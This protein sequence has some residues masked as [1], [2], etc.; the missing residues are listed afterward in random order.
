MQ[1][2][3]VLAVLAVVAA[4]GGTL[5]AMAAVARAT[6]WHFRSVPLHG[7]SAESWA[8]RASVV[9]AVLGALW[10][11]VGPFYSGFAGSATLSL[12]GTTSLA[13]G[14]RSSS[15][16]A[17]NGPAVIPWLALPVLVAHVPF[18]FRA[19]ATR[20]VAQSLCAVVLAAQGVI[21]ISGYGLFF[22]PSAVLMLVAALLASRHHAA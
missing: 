20:P 12:A 19:R 14:P 7:G 2:L 3:S 17:G 4:V 21:G 15:L 9:A 10:L 8:L 13:A 22:A 11:A 18:G 5:L 1:L 6:L 16:L